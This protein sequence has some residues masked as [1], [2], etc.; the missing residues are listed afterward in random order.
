MPLG[1]VVMK[2]R[3]LSVIAASAALAWPA[4]AQ[5]STARPIQFPDSVLSRLQTE[6]A[7]HAEVRLLTKWGPF[8]LE[9]PVLSGTS[10]G[11][12]Q[13]LSD[14][15]FLPDSVTLPKPVPVEWIDM[16]QISVRN[17]M[18]SALRVG[19]AFGVLGALFGLMDASADSITSVLPP[20]R[21][22]GL[23]PATGALLFG[24]VGLVLGAASSYVRPEWKTIYEIKK[25]FWS[26][27]R[28]LSRT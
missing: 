21:Q 20:S 26:K 4:A 12:D 17:P 3:C 23:T 15:S 25:Y 18:K 19:V 2:S 6:M 13:V 7:G 1:G 10:V 24:S 27:L 11:Y 28:S 8:H 16:V 5:I 22:T 14:T 9:A